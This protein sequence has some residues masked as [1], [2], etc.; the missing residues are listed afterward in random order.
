MQATIAIPTVDVEG[1][2]IEADA[3]AWW[4]CRLALDFGEFTR[5]QGTRMFLSREN[6][7]LEEVPALLYTVRSKEGESEND[8]IREIRYHLALAEVE[9]GTGRVCGSVNS[10]ETP[11]NPDRKEGT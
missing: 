1:G 8:F 3:F 4:E 11:V 9:F 7:V 5:V 2:D 6:D 10:A